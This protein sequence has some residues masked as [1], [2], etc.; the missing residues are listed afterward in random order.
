MLEWVLYYGAYCLAG[1]T[2]KLGDDLLDE[3]DKP[4][5]ALGPLALSGL[6]FGLVMT[7]SEWDLVLLSAIVVGVLLSGKVNRPQFLIGFVMIG[8]VLFWI[9]VPVVTSW[10]DWLVILVALLVAAVLDE[11]G[12]DWADSN[13]GRWVSDFFRFRFTLKLSVLILAVV[14]TAFLP[15]AIG[16]WFFDL[17]Y[18]TMGYITRTA[19]TWN[20]EMQDYSRH[21]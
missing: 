9:G 19:T 2:L 4:T 3:L 6:L 1:L 21:P 18:E 14:W 12:N 16:L 11:R 5:I 15:S 13:A 17:G 20:S 10:L 8:I 7:V